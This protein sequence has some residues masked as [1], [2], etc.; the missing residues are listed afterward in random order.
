MGR[1]ITSKLRQTINNDLSPDWNWMQSTNGT[2]ADTANIQSYLKTTKRIK[3]WEY[4]A[5]YRIVGNV[6]YATIESDRR[7]SYNIS[8]IM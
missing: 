1:G 6:I 5:T 2:N 7:P 8:V 4:V 3:L